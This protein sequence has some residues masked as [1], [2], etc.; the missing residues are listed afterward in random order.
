MVF[1][2]G[3]ISFKFSLG[4]VR[5]RLD[6]GENAARDGRRERRERFIDGSF[7][8]HRARAKEVC[9]VITTVCNIVLTNF[10]LF[11]V[12]RFLSIYL[13]RGFARAVGSASKGFSGQ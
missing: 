9:N 5:E 2:A 1:Y 6:G 12:Q 7:G 13:L 8:A 4:R 3:S 10:Y 11:L